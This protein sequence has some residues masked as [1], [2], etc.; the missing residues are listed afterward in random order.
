MIDKGKAMTNFIIAL[1]VIGIASLMSLIC[2]GVEAAS[3]D[4]LIQEAHDNNPQIQEKFYQWKAA[5]YKITSVKSLDDPT[6]N[7]GYLVENLET[8]VGP[9]EHKVGV[10]Q[11]I[12]FP[13]KLN[14][15]G[16]AQSKHA[17]MLKEQYEAT[18]NI[19]IKD[20]KFA[21]YDVF[22]VDKAIEI[23]EEEKSILEKLEKVSQ[24]R[25]ESNLG[26][27][28]EVIKAQVELSK[29]IK[30][31]Y[32]LKQNRKS[33]AVKLNS[34]LNRPQ[35]T[36][37]EKIM[38]I[39]SKS[40]EYELDEIINKSQNL[41]QELLEANLSIEKSQFEK[42]LARMAYLPDF[43]IGAEYIEIGGGTT[44]LGNDGQ[45]VWMLKASINVPIWFWKLNAQVK[46]KEALLE[47]SKK[48]KENLEN[49]VQFEAQD[50]Y[51]K[52]TT[53]RDI[54]LLY[55]TAL[56]PQAQQA[57]DVSQTGFETGSI[58][59]LDW[60]DTER[61]Y[62]QTRLAYYKAI[63]DYHKSI[64]FLERVVGEEL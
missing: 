24:R 40:F 37:I 2:L 55:E 19:I 47:A 61:T 59:F 44:T 57:F 21:Y 23:N 13:G 14:L 31:L 26:G 25:Y 36:K 17:Q 34:L 50:L 64:A 3:L 16:K 49:Q 56:M 60:L 42:S 6:V 54:V 18:K 51:F 35:E 12:P 32:L 1:R 48:N 7:Y 63:I 62:L 29:I 30:K 28:Q 46:E 10:S 45:D 52:I 38:N 27:Q 41:R 22:W 20:V 15:K 5:E 39:G 53:Y 43:T 58:T 33:L 11:K 8:R 9:Q 4:E